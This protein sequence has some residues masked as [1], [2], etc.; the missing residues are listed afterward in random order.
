MSLG[1]GLCREGR[2]PRHIDTD[3]ETDQGFSSDSHDHGL[4]EDGKKHTVESQN[5]PCSVS[6]QVSS[7]HVNIEPVFSIGDPQLSEKDGHD[8]SNLPLHYECANGSGDQT[9][10]NAHGL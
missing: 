7:N 6:V 3:D 4:V 9:P 2:V 8:F 5:A 10:D 1:S